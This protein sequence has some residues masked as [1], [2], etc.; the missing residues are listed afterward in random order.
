ML[1]RSLC[2]K[3]CDLDVYCLIFLI[4]HGRSGLRLNDGRE[5]GGKTSPLSRRQAD[6]RCTCV[7]PLTNHTNILTST[8]SNNSFQLNIAS[9]Q[10]CSVAEEVDPATE[11]FLKTM[12]VPKEVKPASELHAQDDDLVLM[13]RKR[14]INWWYLTPVLF[15]PVFPIIRIVYAFRCLLCDALRVVTNLAADTGR[16]M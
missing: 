14:T 4:G 15:A 16:I 8:T 11:N 12:Q 10:T 7:L 13:E 2:S 3:L 6:T 9:T 1:R 5:R